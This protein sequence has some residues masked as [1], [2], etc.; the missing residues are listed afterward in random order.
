M[1][2][3]LFITLFIFG[4]VGVILECLIKTNSELNCTMFLV[5]TNETEIYFVSQTHAHKKKKKKNKKTL[6]DGRFKL[7]AEIGAGSFGS[8]LQA[9]DL[10]T[11][12]KVAIKL[13]KKN[14]KH[15]PQLPHEFNVYKRLNTPPCACRCK[16]QCHSGRYA[17]LYF[18]EQHPQG[19]PSEGL[20][21]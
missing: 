10:E 13:E 19:T 1:Q 11:G 6:T 12:S 18:L 21:T 3:N 9:R 4:S 16:C 15:H 7:G 8:V 20:L 5:K 2:R 17:A 14:P